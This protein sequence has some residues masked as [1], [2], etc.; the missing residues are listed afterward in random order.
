MRVTFS[1][2]AQRRRLKRYFFCLFGRIYS[3]GLPS[4]QGG[5]AAVLAT[6]SPALAAA[7]PLEVVNTNDSGA[8]SLR[9]AI[10]YANAN[11]SQ[12]AITFNIPGV[13][14]HVIAANSPLPI[15]TDNGV[16]ID[17]TTQADTNCGSIPNA[18]G[19]LAD[20]KL[21]IVLD[22]S[23]HTGTVLTVE[24]TNVTVKGLTIGD[25]AGA[26]LYADQADGLV[27]LCN[28]FGVSTASNFDFGNGG[29]G[30]RI[31]ESDNV[32]VGDGTLAGANVFGFNGDEG[33][34]LGTNR[35]GSGVSI[36][37]NFFGIS[38]DGATA[39]PN[40][41]D[42]LTI[43]GWTGVTVGDAFGGGNVISG[44]LNDGLFLRDG[45]SVTVLGNYIGTNGIGTA[46]VPNADDGV[47]VQNVG[48]VA[49]I[50]NG[51]MGGANIIAGNGNNGIAAVNLPSAIINGNRIGVG[52]GGQV[53]GNS[54]GLTIW[55]GA[56][57]Q[58]TANHIAN[59][60]REGIRLRSTAGDVAI[61]A[62]S[63]HDNGRVG[64]DLVGNGVTPNDSGDG[65]SGVN[66]LLNFPDINSFGAA[67]STSVTF[68]INLDVPSHGNGYRIDFFKNTAAD[69]TGY[70]EGEIHLGS[71]DVVHPGGNQQFTGSFTANAPVSVGDIISA[72]TTRKTSG[73]TYDITSEFS[74]N[75]SAIN[76]GAKLRGEK[77]VKV[78]DVGGYSLPGTDMIYT[79]T[80]TNIGE[81]VT[82]T[83]SVVII[84]EMPSQM[85]FFN[86]DHDG[87]GP[88]T[89]RVGF[90]E[91]ATTL[92]FNPN[93]DVRFSDA[94]A[95][96]SSFA[97]CTYTPATGYDPAVTFIC[98]N[99]KGQMAAGDPDPSF[100]VS[101]RA[102]IK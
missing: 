53:L 32:V 90:N 36:R 79:I 46:G 59:H 74:L 60:P 51:T 82:D 89:D 70:G 34:E 14:N 1:R 19:G 64:I 3:L 35:P 5:L 47:Q 96:P 8:G 40:S 61:Y 4:R 41:D 13:A 98:L 91:T 39:T 93:T 50:G 29:D 80:I 37:R 84:D 92:S 24:A 26:G 12:D 67:G 71:V 87:S 9:A 2:A 76:A 86:G 18:T 27:L 43:G 49:T 77:S 94:A 57:A 20:R 102:R 10:D 42:G 30:A 38:I 17:G 66:D 68:D 85:T 101:F 58:V 88:S 23:N 28:H 56:T 31:D 69:A 15:I 97:A 33:F 6:L 11:P 100:G 83:D 48:T 44:N 75:Y 72:T 52:A 25:G 16:S 78:L 65:D 7:S 95:K 55:S 21:R 22:G 45:G 81:G 63:I 99:P 73:V 54:T 62:N